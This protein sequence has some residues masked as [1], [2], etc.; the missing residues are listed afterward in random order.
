MKPKYC[1]FTL[2]NHTAI[3]L[4]FSTSAFAADVVWNGSISND[5]TDGANWTPAHTPDRNNS[6]DAV[7]N[8]L[9]NYPVLTASP[10]FGATTP[11]DIFIG[12]GAGTSGRVDQN[13]GSVA[14]AGGNWIFVGVEGGTGRLDITGTGSFNDSGR[15]WVGGSQ[16]GGGGNGILNINTSGTV[17]TNDL[18][19]GSS[20]GTGVIT[21]TA[22]TL[23]T[24]GWN[25]IGKREA[26]VG[27]NGT[28]NITGGILTNNGE[29][30]VIGQGDST[31]A[32][33]ISGGV[34]N[35]LK[36]GDQTF[37]VVGSDNLA[38]ANTPSVTL[39]GSGTINATRTL[40]VG[41]IEAQGGDVSFT[42][43]GKGTMTING[44]TAL[45]NM[46]GELW[47][48]QGAGSNGVI[49]LQAGAI[50]VNNWV[51]IGRNGGTGALNMSGGTITKTGAGNFIIAATGPGTMTQSAGVVNVLNGVTWIGEN[52]NAVGSLAISNTAEFNTQSLVLA[53]NPG[54]SGTI[55]TTGGTMTVG[56]NNEIQIGARGAGVWTQSAGTVNASGWTVVG[57]YN[58]VGASGILNVSGG[59]FN[60]VQLDRNMIVGEETMGTLNVSLTGAVNASAVNG[61]SV[62]NGATGNGTINLDGGTITA[63][64]VHEGT[65]GS[66]AFNFNGGKLVAGAGASSAFMYGLDSVVI[67][68]GGAFIDSGAN[69]IGINSTVSDDATNGTL[70]KTGSGALY[71][72]AFNSYAG[73]TQVNAGTLGGVGNLAGAVSVGGS[74]KL[75]PG[76]PSGVLTI[77]SASF[78]AGGTLAIDIV[79]TAP[80]ADR[81]DVSGTLNIANAKLTLS[82][83]PSSQRYVIA[84]Y[85]ALTPAAGPFATVPTLPAGYTI[86]YA[87]QGSLIAIERPLTAFDNYINGIFPGFED[88][89]GI[90]GENADPDSD[91]SSNILEYALGGN[92]DSGSD[93][94]KVYQII[95]DSSDAGTQPELLLTIAVL[96]GTPAFTPVSGSPT[97]TFGGVT[98]TIQGSVDLANFASPCTVVTPVAPASNPT[99]PAGYTYRTFSLNG[100]NG[101]PGKGFMRVTV[102]R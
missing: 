52:N 79:D 35:N 5:W 41:G 27:G 85:G 7:V 76:A 48:G 10:G 97:A 87:Y 12:R 28:L 91:G 89:P 24:N 26:A 50:Q 19:A 13:A 81:L 101:T 72:N 80:V 71:M 37:F 82:K 51:A 22:G 9:T 66:S 29:R 53:V 65:G 64:S 18:S 30:T 75:S 92:P 74:G 68:S 70:T 86:N 60:Q 42:G 1:I 21:L 32:L 78:A 100:S 62:G 43:S 63:K 45:L 77:G 96:T 69:D 4:C 84:S 16:N 44:A 94:A 38:N 61:I 90:V 40:S 11:R 83:A 14:N 47:A 102:S 3:T 93:G 6:E 23:N 36:V 56:G 58:E 88:N 33:N 67:K 57:R 31:G 8:I 34:Y 54:T 98:Y 25:F 99:P 20:G 49:T 17:D 2:L 73:T 46:T 95:A 15:M 59:T 55:T 39:T